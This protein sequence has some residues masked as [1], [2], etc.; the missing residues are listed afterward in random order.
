MSTKAEIKKRKE[1]KKKIG[2]GMKALLTLGLVILGLIYYG[3]GKDKGG[4]DIPRNTG[5]IIE[6]KEDKDTGI[7]ALNIEKKSSETDKSGDSSSIKGVNIDKNVVVSE[8]DKSDNIV[9]DSDKD[10]DKITDKNE[11]VSVPVKETTKH[12]TEDGRLNINL[13][14]VEELCKLNGIGEKR[15]NDIIDYRETY[16]NFKKT[17]DIMKVKGIKQGVFSKIKDEITCD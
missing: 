11:T 12:Y 8:S 2:L 3:S 14:T 17:E 6:T 15:A 10:T 1:L 16:G 9:K 13:A 4:D 7:K 5:S